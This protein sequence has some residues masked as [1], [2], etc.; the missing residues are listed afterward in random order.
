[1]LPRLQIDPRGL[2]GASRVH[3]QR[4]MH[5]VHCIGDTIERRVDLRLT[6]A[7]VLSK[8]ANIYISDNSSNSHEVE[9]TR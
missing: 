9:S 3:I 8:I 7:T 6:S 1:M 5:G 4:E 2:S